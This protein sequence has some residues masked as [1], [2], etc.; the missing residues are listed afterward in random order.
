MIGAELF[1]GACPY[2]DEI[3]DDADEYFEHVTECTLKEDDDE[4]E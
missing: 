4:E 2:C 3:I 1:S